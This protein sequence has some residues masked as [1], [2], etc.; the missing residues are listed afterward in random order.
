MPFFSHL[1][2]K[3][4][5]E[6]HPDLQLIFNRIIKLYDIFILCGHRGEIAQNKAFD[7]GVSKLRY[8]DGKHNSVP[9]RAVDVAPYPYAAKKKTTFYYLAGLVDAVAI[10]LY[11]KGLITH[12][13]R[14]GGDWDSDKDF[15]DQTFYDLAHFELK[16][17]E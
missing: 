4:L 2:K 12:K 16:A 6:C 3:R 8:P 5:A 15:D 17:C 7:D 9:S 13:V 1:S 14:W 11:D 10:D